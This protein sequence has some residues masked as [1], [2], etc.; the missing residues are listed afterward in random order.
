MCFHF[1]KAW[2]L[3]AYDYSVARSPVPVSIRRDKYDDLYVAFHY[4]T[5]SQE[6]QVWSIITAFS[7]YQPYREK[8]IVAD[9]QLLAETTEMSRDDLVT[10]LAE[11]RAQRLSAD[12]LTSKSIVEYERANRFLPKP[13]EVE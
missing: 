13:T 6:D 12:G 9:A 1:R 11:H 4:R 8:W 2:F 7:K 5:K 3:H 10:Y